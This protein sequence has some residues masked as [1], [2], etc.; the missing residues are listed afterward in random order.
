M[1]VVCGSPPLCLAAVPLPLIPKLH[2]RQKT[3]FRTEDCSG[4]KRVRQT[5]GWGRTLFIFLFSPLRP[6][7]RNFP[8]FHVFMI[9]CSLVPKLHFGTPL[10]AQFYCSRM[11]HQPRRNRQRSCLS[12]CVP[13]WSLGTRERQTKG[14]GRAL[15]YFPL[16]SSFR[17]VPETFP[18]QISVG[19]ARIPVFCAWVSAIASA[20]AASG[21]GFSVSPSIARIM[22]PTCAFCAPPRPVAAAF[23]RR[24]AYS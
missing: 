10:S 1:T 19:F 24:G 5:K 17:S 4:L 21:G 16:Q 13:K 22:N 6:S 9:S 20:S 23:T 14:W 11:R 7:V 15:F 2:L 3:L 18:P 12:K 8:P